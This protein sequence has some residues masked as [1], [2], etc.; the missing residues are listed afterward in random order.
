MNDIIFSR[1]YQNLNDKSKSIDKNIKQ[2]SDTK[3][4]YDV[5]ANS[6]KENLIIYFFIIMLVWRFIYYL[7]IRINDIITFLILGVIMYYL[8]LNDYSSFNAFKSQK[9]KEL[10]F[11]QK[12][13]FESDMW[14]SEDPSYL[15]GIK[16][17][18]LVK[19]SYLYLDP[20]I[21]Q[22]FY[23]IRE[24]SQYDI[25][26]YAGALIHTNH[27]IGLAYET[28]L[29]FNKT[30]MYENYTVAVEESKKA[31]NQ[32][33]N[34]I[35]QLPTAFITYNKF[36]E[37]LK[38]LHQLLNVHLENMAVVFKNQN[39]KTDLHIYAKPDDFYDIDFFISPNDTEERGY[40][41]G[42]NLY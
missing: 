38:I 12:M 27:V 13:M 3:T 41:A 6:P 42:Y 15:L 16:P 10:D 17:E 4:I 40:M 11:V 14:K 21:V 8:V 35:F 25:S 34:V 2:I 28:K 22:L 23:N 29:G 30:A 24:F 9:Q 39:V 31:L 32:L 1:V 20:F 5:L 36:K 18:N 37:S 33:K 7:P 26:A 19:K